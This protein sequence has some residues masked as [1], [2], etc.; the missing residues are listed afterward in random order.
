MSGKL[1][2]YDGSGYKGYLP[3]EFD[4]IV[5]RNFQLPEKFRKVVV[6]L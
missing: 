2:F 4:L 5:D 1:T 6:I 3:D